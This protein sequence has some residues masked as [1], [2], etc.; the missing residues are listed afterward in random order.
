MT[1]LWM[2]GAAAVMAVSIAGVQAQSTGSQQPPTQSPTSQT[3]A[4]ADT[5]G[6]TTTLRG[7]VYEEKDIPG[8]TPNVAEQAG[9][10]E[11][12]VLVASNAPSAS[13]AAT[14]ATGTTGSTASG[15]ATAGT[16]G[17]MSAPGKAKAFKL[18]KIADEQLKAV[19]GKMVEVTGKVDAEHGDMARTSATGAAAAGANPD[20]SMGP[21]RVE[22]P[23]FEVTSIREV[24][25]TCPAT[26]DIKK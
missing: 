17:S 24:E 26:P 20:R 25:G 4:T 8:R 22:L 5:Q 16:S 11:D 23:E 15:S 12:Y 6:T 10:L 1:R 21:D 9:V 13:G 2:S 18:E 7:C 3:Q 14:S 19:V